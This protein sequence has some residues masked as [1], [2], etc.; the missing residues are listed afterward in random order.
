M[1]ES[2]CE[3]SLEDVDNVGNKDGR[4]AMTLEGNSI[5]KDAEVGRVMGSVD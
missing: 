1:E 4:G 5:N 3:L 2:T